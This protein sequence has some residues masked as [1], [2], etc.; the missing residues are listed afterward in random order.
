MSRGSGEQVRKRNCLGNN[1]TF[2]ANTAHLRSTAQLFNFQE[3]G[4]QPAERHMALTDQMDDMDP[5][6]E[7]DDMDILVVD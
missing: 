2:G 4:L 5:M 3:A 6:D 1:V 7:V